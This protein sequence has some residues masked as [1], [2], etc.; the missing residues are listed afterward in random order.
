MKKRGSC[1]DRKKRPLQIFRTLYKVLGMYKKTFIF[2]IVALGISVG[3]TTAGNFIIRDAVDRLISHRVGAMAIIGF[4]LLFLATALLRGVSAFFSGKGSARSSEKVALSLRTRL[5]MHFQLLPFAYHDRMQTGELVQRATS[6]VDSVR[7]FYSDQVPGVMRIVF[8]FIINLAAIFTLHWQLALG[9][10][11]AV[12]F[13]L[14]LSLFFFKRIVNGFESYQEQEGRL[15][16]SIQETL[17][18]IRVVKA[19]ARQEW[20]A[21][22]FDTFNSEQCRRGNWLTFLHAA[23][24]P[25][26]I[27]LCGSQF[28][29][30][31]TIGAYLTLKGDISYGTYIAFTAMVAAIIWPLQELGRMIIELSKSSVSFFR[32]K[33][34]MDAVPEDLEQG[35]ELTHKLQGNIRF[36]NVNFSYDRGTPVLRNISLD[37]C[38]G[39]KIAVL[40]LTGSGK[41]TLVNLL[42]RFYDPDEGRILIDNYAL[43]S[44]TKRY[45]RKNIGMVE[46][47][48]FLFTASIKENLLFGTD[49]EVSRQE[50]EKAA[51]M[52]CIHK[53]I[54]SFP[55]GYD[56]LIGEKGVSLSGGQRQR[57]AIARTILKD[58]K[59]LVLD[60]STSAID[61]RTEK[62]IQAALDTLMRGRTS[63]IIAHRIE[64]LMKAD[65][66]IVMDKGA[67]VETGIHEEL[68]K[69]PGIYKKIFN[70]QSG[71]GKEKE[72]ERQIE[73]V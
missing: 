47:E 69:R 15:T 61:A 71:Y 43:T 5:F 67:I 40:G 58:P 66:I 38:A 63:F 46:Q 13:I 68:V 48:P 37:V 23:Y 59:I 70:I 57:I 29:A 4:A 21:G 44:L 22:H 16:A 12:P 11:V 24:W 35:I 51:K 30:I 60:D 3:L 33:T 52:A 55:E 31:A 27:L 10:I 72:Y 8:L 62:K 19:F 9:S 65:K 14:L 1:G 6:D 49:R 2:S 50:M 45:L 32:I 64:T 18:G 17:T 73:T 42:P 20:E 25:L 41:T 56:T 28:I 54:L 53:T 26:S 39:E 7:K 34:I 36:Q